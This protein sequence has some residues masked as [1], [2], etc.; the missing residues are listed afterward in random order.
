MKDFLKNIKDNLSIVVLTPEFLGEIYQ[1]INIAYFVDLPYIRYFSVAQIVPDG[2]LVILYIFFLL[3]L[4]VITYIFLDVINEYDYIGWDVS[5]SKFYSILSLVLII[6]FLSTLIYRLVGNLKENQNISLIFIIFLQQTG[7]AVCTLIIIA[8]LP[9][10]YFIKNGEIKI[11]NL[12][13]PITLSHLILTISFFTFLYFTYNLTDKTV[14]INRLIVNTENLYNYKKLK[15]KL[16]EDKEILNLEI[17]Y[18]N[19]DYVFYKVK[20]KNSAHQDG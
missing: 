2:I 3:V 15:H 8:T 14:T 19:R 5:F 16:S 10:L 18:T 20:T 11:F 6:P 7:I 1:I 9:H 12:L 4:F 13:K 17:L